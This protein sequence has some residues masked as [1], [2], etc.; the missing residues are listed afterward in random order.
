VFVDPATRQIREATPDDIGTLSTTA[1]APGQ[2]T[3]TQPTIQGPGGAVGVMLGP[4]F[5]VY[6]I[7]TKIGE[8]AIR[9]EEVSGEK[10][11]GE[12]VVPVDPPSS[13]NAK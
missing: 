8:D 11:I 1:P 13:K 12:R 4:E 7:G 2:V 9:V 6:M 5:Q 3:A 10:S